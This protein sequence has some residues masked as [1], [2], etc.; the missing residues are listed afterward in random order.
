MS[1]RFKALSVAVAL[2]PLL[3]SAQPA[4][5]PD[6]PPVTL[7]AVLSSVV[8]H[9]PLIEAARQD[10]AA[11]EA[12]LRAAQGGFDPEVRARAT[13]IPFGPYPYTRLETTVQQPTT[14][15]GTTVFG[16][17]RYGAGEIPPYYGNLETNRLGEV[18]AGV[19]V[20]LF[21]NGAVDRRRASLSRA[22]IN[23]DAAAFAVDQAKLET[24]R[25]AAQRYWDWVA[26]GRRRAV[27]QALLQIARD[28]DAQI[29]ER[30]RRGDIPALERTDNS[31]ALV[32]REGQV[33]SA[34]RLLQQTAIELSL[35]FRDPD[36]DPLLPPP[37]RLPQG[38]PSL[39]PPDF[40]ADEARVERVLARRPDLQRLQ[41]QKEAQRVEQGFALNQQRPQV[42]VSAA[43]I[44]DLGRGSEKL[45][46]PE[47]ELGLTVEIPTFNRAATG[48]SRAIEASVARLDAQLQLQRERAVA[49]TRDA[50]SALETA[51]QRVALA[52]REV[53]LARS[54]E[55]GERARFFMGDSSLFVVNLREQAAAEA[56]VREVD[57]MAEYFKAEASL[58]AA[59][60]LPFT[61]A[62]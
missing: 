12:E 21:R 48:R 53:E 39:P 25:T 55:Q 22:G 33:V 30:V 3:L 4:P 8:A 59:I 60:A 31:R 56:A 13:Q 10:V 29:A 7:P 18:R 32:Q 38:F 43:A 1:P 5:P 37:E 52:R 44:Q 62:G 24:S 9:Y 54:L 2:W 35:F 27:A 42:D 6:E 26:A 51:H 61:E 15:W 49:E 17:W 28:R 47:L 16:G 14:L 11:A 34:D 41:T 57:A 23:Q 19:S 46:K 36:G 40:L 45:G 58:R 20:P 50:L